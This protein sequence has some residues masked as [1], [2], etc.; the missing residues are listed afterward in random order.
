MPHLEAESSF[1]LFC[2]VLD[3]LTDYIDRIKNGIQVPQ[4]KLRKLGTLCEG[5][6]ETTP[7]VW[8]GSLLRFEWVRSSL[9]G[10]GHDERSEG[11]YRFV[12]M[13]TEDA[14]GAPFAHAHAFGCAFTKDG[15]MYAHGV[16]GNGGATNVIDVF[17][18]EDLIRW[19]AEEAIALPKEWKIYNTSVCKGRDGYV[20][21]IEVEG[22]CE[23]LGCRY[24]ILFA[25]SSDCRHFTLLPVEEHMFLKERYTACPSIRYVDGFYYM[26]YLERMPF[27]RW[28][29][30]IVRSRDLSLFEPGIVNPFMMFDEEDKRVL[31]PDRFD[32]EGLLRLEEAVNC[33]ASDVDFCEHEGKTVIL[34]SWGNQHGKEYLARAEYEGGLSEF[35][36]SFFE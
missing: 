34:Y 31:R 26:V 36:Q 24:T 29:P 20:M 32:D 23:I 11:H 16:R 12:D 9:W 7:V 2:E 28:A 22:P 25:T 18:S 5:V 3:M 8:Q 1:P 14:V 10:E 4:K 21:A 13:A 27:A 6:V 33:N 35:L 19:K 30:Y 15:V 17:W